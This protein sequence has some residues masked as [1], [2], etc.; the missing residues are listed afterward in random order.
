ME[1]HGLTPF[2]HPSQKAYAADFGGIHPQSGNEGFRE[3][4]GVLLLLMA[5]APE[6][7]K[8]ESLK[9]VS[10]S[11]E[12]AG[13]TQTGE[14]EA[15]HSYRA[16]WH[17]FVP[18][19]VISVLYLVGWVILYFM[20]LSGG[21]LARLFIVVLAVGVPLLFANAF[22]RYQT[23]AIELFESHLKYH[24]GWPKA[25]PVVL[26][27]AIVDNVRYS[28]GLSGRLFGGGTVIVQLLAGEAI[29][30]A[31]VEKPEDA[32]EKIVQMMG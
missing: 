32:A 6:N 11:D 12:I 3:K 29:G 26:P 8:R 16:H 31:D 22:L 15:L 27:Y 7:S 30:I 28:R 25:E 10:L 21:N 17:I 13:T 4:S 14:R 2:F 5:T 9:T 18:T 1:K 20:E 24:T 19:V 23:I